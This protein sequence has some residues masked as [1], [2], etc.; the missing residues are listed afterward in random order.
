MKKKV[1]IVTI[2]L[3]IEGQNLDNQILKYYKFPGF[4]TIGEFR[5]D[6]EN[7]IPDVWQP[8]QMVI[9]CDD[10]K[11]VIA[12]YPNIEG[13]LPL[14]KETVQAWIDCGSPVEGGID[15]DYYN[16]PIKDLQGNL[17]LAFEQ[18][19]LET[20]AKEAAKSGG[21]FSIHAQNYEY[22][23]KLGAEW[24]KQQLKPAIPTE[25]KIEETANNKFPIM[26]K[27]QVISSNIWV[28][29]DGNQELRDG[30]VMGYKQALTDLNLKP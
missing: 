26:I 23:F 19:T 14:S 8:R 3:D 11:N 30:Y 17:Q 16:Q 27:E 18:Q 25:D 15:I 9:L 29:Y 5:I 4:Y 7:Y 13:T 6:N 10:D 22:M 21:P 2:S 24:Q 28:E 12:S 1:E 20:A